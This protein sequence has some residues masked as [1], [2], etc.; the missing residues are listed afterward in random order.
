MCLLIFVTYILLWKH[1]SIHT[2]LKVIKLFNR[3]FAEGLFACISSCCVS[4]LELHW[5]CCNDCG[6]TV[7]LEWE[8]VRWSYKESRLVVRKYQVKGIG[9]IFLE[10]IFGWYSFMGFANYPK[11]NYH[12]SFD[13]V[14]RRCSFTLPYNCKTLFCIWSGIVFEGLQG[15][16]RKKG[17]LY[18]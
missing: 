1:C 12:C 18:L 16:R 11:H 14:F 6:D 15:A 17:G 8:L 10:L 7:A 2:A 4:C 3:V 5:C 9:V 13:L